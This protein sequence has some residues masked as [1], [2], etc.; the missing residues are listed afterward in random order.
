MK[1]F[2]IVLITLAAFAAPAQDADVAKNA[3]EMS[4]AQVK[5]E[6]PEKKKGRELLESAAGQA[7][8]LPMDFQPLAL[9]QAAVIETTVDKTKAGELFDLAF[10]SA[11]TLP[12]KKDRRY[13]ED[14]Q[15]NIARELAKYDPDHALELL[16]SMPPGPPDERDYRAP[17]VDALMERTLNDKKSERA[18]ELLEEF[19]ARGMFPY[20][21]AQGL[22]ESLTPDDQRR[23]AIFALTNA[24]FQQRP[25]IDAYLDFI[26]QLRKQFP[27]QALETAV[28]SLAKAAEDK[29][30][31]R[32]ARTMTFTTDAGNVSLDD[33]WDVVYFK[34]ADL[35]AP[36][37]A[38][39]IKRVSLGRPGLQAALQ[40]WPGGMKQLEDAPGDATIATMEWTGGP[41]TEEQQRH[42]RDVARE[43]VLFREVM[44]NMRKD[45]AQALEIQK[46]IPAARL[47]GRCVR[48]VIEAARGKD[49]SEARSLLAKCEGAAAGIPEVSVRPELYAAI[50]AVAHEKLKDDEY[51]MRIFDKAIADYTAALNLTPND[52]RLYNNRGS[53][54]AAE[55]K[56]DQAIVDYDEALRIDPNNADA[57]RNREG[58]MKAKAG[59]NAGSGQ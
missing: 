20:G 6:S 4:K 41:L 35:V 25:D 55:G 13:R 44:I 30:G 5:K 19:S 45:P 10:A 32:D 8:A 51:A 42:A 57:K 22:I 37:D 58:T 59:G 14:F 33:P 26:R 47:R 29:Q 56:L 40:R 9:L 48:L 52:A 24:S 53:A 3:A 12:S 2:G 43:G 54:Y 21:A 36:Y 28:R 34:L 11:A 1:Q 27:P 38:D 16:R 15:A 17:A 46:Q 39:W 7:G 18:M 31:M 49:E 23:A 50:A